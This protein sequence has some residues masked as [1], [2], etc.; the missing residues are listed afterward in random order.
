M[1]TKISHFLIFFL[2][3]VIL[4]AAREPPLKCRMT[5]M[6][7]DYDKTIGKDVVCR[8]KSA[9]SVFGIFNFGMT[10]LHPVDKIKVD[11][12]ASQNIFERF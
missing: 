9:R 2:Q 8:Y 1:M 7:C 4:S 3:T 6:A 5:N 11:I 10:L 12:Y